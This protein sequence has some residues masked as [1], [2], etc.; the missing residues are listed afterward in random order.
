[1]FTRAANASEGLS[2]RPKPDDLL[3]KSSGWVEEPSVRLYLLRTAHRGD[4]YTR[5][6][7]P[8][9]Y[10]AGSSITR[11]VSQANHHASLGM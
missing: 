2:F 10:T 3:C 11:D 5:W 8:P 7:F 1:V 9:E 4:D 6:S